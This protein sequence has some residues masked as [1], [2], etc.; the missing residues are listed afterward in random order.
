[1]QT[2]VAARLVSAQVSRDVEANDIGVLFGCEL[3]R[4]G[5]YA[6]LGTD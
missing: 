3:Q 4:R 2:L 1:M 6:G 5:S